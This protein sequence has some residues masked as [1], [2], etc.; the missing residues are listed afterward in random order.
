LLVSGGVVALL[1]YGNMEYYI[2]Y[3]RTLQFLLIM[4]GIP[5]V[6][7]ANVVNYFNKIKSVADYDILSYI[8]LWNLPG[9]NQ[10]VVDQNAPIKISDQMQ[11]IGYQN[12]NALY[13]LGTFTFLIFLYFL[14]LGL[15]AVIKYF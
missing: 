4:P 8:N 10:I 9:L 7:P 15:V 2:I 6:L 3:V 13:G 12:R 11:N 5:I 14:R 1:G